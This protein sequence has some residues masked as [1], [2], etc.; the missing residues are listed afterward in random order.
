MAN[1]HSR[2]PRERRLR[3]RYRKKIWT[4]GIIMLI[5][6]LVVGYVLST[7]FLVDKPSFLTAASATPTPRPVLT[8]TE[9]PTAA[10]TAEPNIEPAIVFN[11]LNDVTEEPTAV[12][13][14]EPTAE[15][16]AQPTVEPTKKPDKTDIPKT[17]DNSHFGYAYLMIAVAAAG[18]V[19]LAATR[20][21]EGSK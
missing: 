7:M 16:T 17:G 8:V 18:L 6:G 19:V 11:S 13:T 12:P 1:Y 3:A 5:I 9:A 15:P 21:K 20:R 10:P 4:C 14:A 2:S